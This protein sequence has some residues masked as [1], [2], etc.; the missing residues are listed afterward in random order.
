M[1]ITG[2][3]LAGLAK[4]ATVAVA[5]GGAVQQQQAAKT[6]KKAEQKRKRAQAKLAIDANKTTAE[7]VDSL[8]EEQ[9]KNRR[10][11]ASVLTSGF[12]PPTLGRTGLLG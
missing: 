1:A 9:K 2:L 4:A 6:G 12:T 11:S 7:A 3:T 5:V 10:R 8:S